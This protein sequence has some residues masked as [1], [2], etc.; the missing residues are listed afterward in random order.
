M[1]MVPSIND[2]KAQT[3]KQNKLD[4]MRIKKTFPSKDTIKKA[5]R[6]STEW[7]KILQVMYQVREELVFRLHK[8]LL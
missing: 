3:T 7:K 4:I 1:A 6:R 5:K 2:T 8:E